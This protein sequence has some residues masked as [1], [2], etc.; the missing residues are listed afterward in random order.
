MKAVILRSSW[1]TWIHGWLA[2]GRGG[3]GSCD[4]EGDWI[5]TGTGQAEL[6]R[7]GLLEEGKGK[8]HL[9]VGQSV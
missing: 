7:L 4:G 1:P 3:G 8:T 9:V 2:G 5:G 6:E